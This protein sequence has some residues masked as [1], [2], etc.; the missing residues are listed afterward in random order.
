MQTVDFIT[1]E[2]QLGSKLA[3]SVE[4]REVSTF[5][6]LLASLSADA[7]DFS[8]FSLLKTPDETPLSDAYNNIK[9]N[10]G[11]K[12]ELAPSEVNFLIGK[13]NSAILSQSGLDQLRLIDC[14]SPEPLSVRDD[15]KY[16]GLEIIHNCS[17]A[18]QSK[19]FNSDINI[20][21]NKINTAGLYQQLAD[22]KI[23]APLVNR[24]Q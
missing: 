8:Q 2:H 4:N 18:V 23:N 11:P 16:V 3:N 5:A 7:L 10:V 19:H 17:P 15:P 9:Q 21:S 1:S 14:L 20:K 13:A 24:Y 6:W 22:E 12:R